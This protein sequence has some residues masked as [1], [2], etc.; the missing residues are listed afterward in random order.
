MAIG[1][2]KQKAGSR[3]NRTRSGDLG[4]AIFL[5]VCGSHGNTPVLCDYPSVKR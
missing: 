3:V 4:V 1:F 2:F 5:I